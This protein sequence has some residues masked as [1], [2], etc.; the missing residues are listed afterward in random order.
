[1]PQR[2]DGTNHTSPA[3]APSWL[4]PQPHVL[5]A[6]PAQRPLSFKCC[7]LARKQE[8]TPRDAILAT[9]RVPGI[10]LTCCAS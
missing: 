4:S 5:S 2:R 6:D 7:L 8:L 1:V 9:R 3:S 10:A